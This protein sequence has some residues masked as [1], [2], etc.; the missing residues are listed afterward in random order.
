[1]SSGTHD[2]TEANGY[3]GRTEL[4][5]IKLHNMIAVRCAICMLVAFSRRVLFILENPRQSVVTHFP[6]FEYILELAERLDH[7]ALGHCHPVYTS[8]WRV[9]KPGYTR[10]VL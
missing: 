10:Y 5:W 1:M 7:H 4:D 9:C 3:M 6:Y 8:W 2:R